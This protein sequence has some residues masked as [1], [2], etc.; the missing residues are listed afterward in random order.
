MDG[1]NFSCGWVGEGGGGWVAGSNGNKDHLS[2]SLSWVEAELGNKHGSNQGQKWLSLPWAWH[3]S[4]PACLLVF[5]SLYW[6]FL[7]SDIVQIINFLPIKLWFFYISIWSHK[8]TCS[9]SLQA[10]WPPQDS[11]LRYSEMCL[12]FSKIIFMIVCR[13]LFIRTKAFH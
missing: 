3:S 5:V 11:C 13:R 10:N 8:R 12:I 4:A 1:W 7:T 9:R 2:L 6:S